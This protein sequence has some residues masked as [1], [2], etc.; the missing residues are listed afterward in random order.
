MLHYLKKSVFADRIKLKILRWRRLFWITGMGPKCNQ[1]CPYRREQ[2]YT[3]TH[4]HTHTLI[5]RQREDRTER[6]LQ[7]L[8]IGVMKP[9][10]KE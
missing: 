2:V 3:H 5:Q 7:T 8:N 9:Q 4:T 6:N 10:T 1:K